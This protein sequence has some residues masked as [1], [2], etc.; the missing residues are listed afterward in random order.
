M[1]ALLVS[2]VSVAFAEIGDKTQ[3]LALVLATRFRKPWPIIGG[4]LVATLV[5]HGIAAE[6]GAWLSVTITP[7]VLRWTVALSFLAM[8]AWIL[9]PDRLD[10]KPAAYSY[11][12]FVSTL[13]AFFLVE[14][15]DKTQVATVL[16]AA[17]Y[18]AIA[19]VVVGTTLGM[20]AANAPVVFA[21]RY[22]ADKLPL[23]LVR[24]VA[25]ALF[26]LIGVAVAAAGEI[27]WD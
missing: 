14:I 3:L 15:G 18:N 1:E 4:I 26:L 10:D 25:A 12:A 11:G 17:K 13:I 2:I 8:G 9:V 6:L 22:A 19:W 27:P 16:L 5:N 20:L 21:G 7:A 24:R 23:R